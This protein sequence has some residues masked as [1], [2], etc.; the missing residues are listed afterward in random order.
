MKTR[1]EIQRAAAAVL[2]IAAAWLSVPVPAGAV[3]Q[4]FEV[5]LSGSAND[6]EEN[7]L[8]TVAL[9]ETVL[10][11]G[12]LYRRV[13]LRFAN[14]TIPR[15]AVITRAY[16]EF[17]VGGADSASTKVKV[18]AH[19]TDNP[20]QFSTAAFD[21]STRVMLDPP[22][23]WTIDYAWQTVDM[24]HQSPELK[25]LVQALVKRP[26]WASGNAM[27][28][29]IEGTGEVF[30]RAK[31]WDMDPAKAPLLHIEYTASIFT[32]RISASTDDLHQSS[33]GTVVNN[34]VSV[35]LSTS[36]YMYSGWRFQNVD[37]P[38]G[39]TIKSAFLKFVSTGSYNAVTGAYRLLGERRLNA[40]TFTTALNHADT[41]M[42]RYLNSAIP[43]TAYVQWSNLPAWQA[44]VE[45]A[46]VDVKSI[47][48]EIVGQPGW[49]NSSK[50]LALIFYTATPSLNGQTRQVVAFEN[51]PNKA[52]QLYIEY[53]E[54]GGGGVSTP[55]AMQLSQSELGRS[56]FEGGAPEGHFFE[57][58]NSGGSA[59]SYTRTIS[60][61]PSSPTGWL[62]IYPAAASGTLGAGERQN[63]S[64]V[65][66]TTG[67]TAGTYEAFITFSAPGAE[68]A[69][70][71]VRVSLSVLKEGSVSCGDIP[72]YTQ[73]IVS[74]AVMIFLDLS[75]SMRDEV[76][77]IPDYFDWTASTTPDLKAV[78]QAIVNR[79][80][81][82]AGNAISFLIDPV[83]GAGRRPARSFD[84]YSPSA[85]KLEVEY[86]DGDEVKTLYASV[87]QPSDDAIAGSV[88]A[89]NTTTAYLDLGAGAVG[90]RFQEITI[91]KNAVI[92]K[93]HLRF[94]P[95]QSNDGALNLKISADDS[96]NSATFFNGVSMAS[97][98]R[99]LANVV[100][101]PNPWV[102][103]TIEKKIDSAKTVI[104]ELVKDTSIA[105]GFA[106][107]VNSD[108][109]GYGAAID[110]TKVHVGCSPHTAEHQ[111]KIYAAL[112]LLMQPKND[113][114]FSPS[115]LA[116]KKYFAAEKAD[117][118]GALFQPA[119]CQPKFLIQV[120]DGLG[121]VDSTNENVM[122]R[123]GLLADQG[124]SAVGIGFGVPEGEKEQIFAFAAVA[125]ARGKA[126]SSDSLYAMHTEDA[127]GK[128][129]PYMAGN[130]DDLTNAFRAIMNNVKGIVFYGSAPAATTSTDLGDTVILSSF[131]GANWTGNL[132]AIAKNSDGSWSHLLWDAKDEV[133]AVRKVFTVDE[134]GNTIDYGS[135]LSDYLCRPIGD[136]INSTPVVVG[137]PPFFYRFDDYPAFKRQHSVSAPRPKTIYVGANDGLLHAIDL[138]TG[139]EKWAFL[140]PSLKPKLAE[141][142]ANPLTN[143]CATGYCH[144]YLLDG[145]PQ[146]AD[147]YAKFGALSDQWRT[148]LVIGQRQGGA[149]YTAL[150]IT[151]GNSPGAAS[152]PARFLWELTDAEMGETWTDAAIERV[153]DGASGSAWG[154]FVS[155]G[156]AVNKNLQPTKEAYLFGV[157]ADTGA[158][159]WAGGQSKVKL[160]AEQYKV[161]YRDLLGGALFPGMKA[162]IF[163]RPTTFE[164]T[165][166]SVT[167]TSPTSGTLYLTNVTGTDT[168]KTNDPIFFPGNIVPG[169][170]TSRMAT[171][172]TNM[173]QTIGAQPNN[174]L[175]SPV[176][177][178]FNPADGKEDCIY[179]GDLY[180]TLFRVDTIGKGQS[181]SVSRLFKFNPYPASPDLQ[182]IRGKASTAYSDAADLIWVFY[183]T[184]RYETAG[185]KVSSQQQYF[186]GLKDN[187][188]P[189]ATA[190]SLADL[191]AL[192]ARFTSATF[193]D[194]TR[195]VRTV[196]GANPSA[197]SWAL[198]LYAGQAGWNG[199]AG[200]GGS[201]RVFTK[202]LVV[203]GIVFF[204]TFVPDADQCTGSGDTWLFALDY[205]TGLPPTK[206][207]FDLNADGKFTDADKL[208]IDGSKVA[209]VGVY[210]GRGVGS[211]PVLHQDTMFVTTSNSNLTDFD[212]NLGNNGLGNPTGLN[213]FK[214]NIPQNRIRVESWK[215][216]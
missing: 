117:A 97:R 190:L 48:Q 210:V 172:N 192:E 199:P 72:L 122:Q 119:A 178:N 104:K 24:V 59:M 193:G 137:A 65:F 80:G 98:P 206:P 101:S 167:A 136:I 215:H 88:G 133:P 110:F 29:V 5:R 62:S 100:W 174:A 2:L 161:D 120:T 191:S 63:F 142:L 86:V 134:S 105:W 90:V 153:A 53:G 202:P 150:D 112:D 116:A 200:S 12:G 9:G 213:A 11:L 42:R 135:A 78:V 132:Q 85:A 143:P 17:T 108:A 171:A 103:V 175:N 125:N 34:N 154:V 22:I 128:A 36:L 68:P 126:S 39:T 168:I 41:P 207:V 18:S 183:G 201:E 107:W 45:Y 157:Q 197:N 99:T 44:G 160:I 148:L 40:P 25:T 196:Y 19:A 27:A 69:E 204:T 158:G 66:D 187:A 211:Q 165:V 152:G 93:A 141:A 37:V 14:I 203:G 33:T 32:A 173:Q 94:V 145:S 71:V 52:A 177:A 111:A 15:D 23:E 115:I 70:T 54:S 55:A 76:D 83:G 124:V 194:R 212:G 156:Y 75:G 170:P 131:N 189:R 50:S 73:N 57:L 205:K 4:V 169:A 21:I 188:A 195:T 121:N 138:A 60:F 16:I 209:P 140:P 8:G 214:V 146:V 216:N 46:S 49:N 162:L 89:I 106:T 184:G 31:S 13:G 163:T 198:K 3:D 96:N 92:N 67:L 38:E 179:V 176:T 26:G 56:C 113:T 95:F 144:Q 127:G 20:S 208:T 159:L 139:A 77:V 129:L 1:S 123:T 84:G 47:V 166:A 130:K 155:S 91:P 147:V 7:H 51:D 79:S 181:P 182:P 28:F 81:W 10:D 118:Y 87:K 64:L 102:G 151:T 6:A 149:A 74:P 58:I 43:K 109:D 82:V 61:T 186:F 180:G 30:R 35:L 164:A 114:P 185:D